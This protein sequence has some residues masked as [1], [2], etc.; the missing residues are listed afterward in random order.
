MHILVIQSSPHE[1]SSSN[2][3]AERFAQGA[4]HVG[5]TVEVFDAGHARIA[6]C[7][8]CDACA[9]G[10]ACAIDDDMGTLRARLLDPAVRLVAFVTPLHFSGVSSQL[11]IV[12]DR[13]HAIEAPLRRRHLDSVLI[14]AAWDDNDWTMTQLTNAYGAFTRYMGMTS[15]GTV[16]GLGCG[17]PQDTVESAAYQRAL[18]LGESLRR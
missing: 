14:C 3:L 13:L 12:I 15:R 6:P 18:A 1:R 2:I 4:R 10:G 17:T 7:V 8:A 5:N 11:K 9:H 16:L